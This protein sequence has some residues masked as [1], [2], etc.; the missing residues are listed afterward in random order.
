MVE[1]AGEAGEAGA[2]RGAPRECDTNKFQLQ[3]RSWKSTPYGYTHTV[4]FYPHPMLQLKSESAGTLPV[5]TDSK[6]T[7]VMEK[8][9]TALEVAVDTLKLLSEI[10]G[11]VPDR[12]IIIDCVKRLIEIHKAVSDDET[13]ASEVLNNILKVSHVLAKGLRDSHGPGQHCETPFG[14]IPDWVAESRDQSFTHAK[15]LGIVDA[16][17]D[18]R[19]NA[20]R[21]AFNA[22]D[23]QGFSLN[24]SFEQPGCLDPGCVNLRCELGGKGGPGGPGAVGGPGGIGEGPRVTVFHPQI[25]NMTVHGD[26]TNSPSDTREK[27][28][29]W[30]SPAKVAISQRDAAQKRHP[31]TGLWLLGERTEFI[32]WIY[33][34][35]SL[36]WLEGISGSG[37]TMLSS[38]IIATL[39]ARAEPLAYFYFDT[40][41]SEQR[42]VTQLLCS[43]VWQISA[44]GPSPDTILNKLWRCSD[45]QDLPTDTELISDALIPILKELTEPVYIML[46]AL[47]E[48]SERDHLLTTITTILDADL[49]NVHLLLTSRPEVPRSSTKLAEHAVP[50]CLE[51]CTHQ[52]IESYLTKKLSNFDYG[53]SAERQGEIRKSLLK[54]GSGMFLL[55]SL[56][57][58]ELRDCDGSDH[59]I[60]E[61]L[62]T[63]P[64]SL[65]EIY[66]RII[67]NIKKPA[68]VSAVLRAMN[69]LI[70]SEDSLTVK[71]II[72]ELAFDFDQEPLRFSKA[73]R[74]QRNTFLK[75]CAG[76]VAVSQDEWDDED[77]DYAEV[78]KLVHASVK[79]YFLSQKAP[80]EAVGDYQH[81]SKQ[82]A[83]HLLAR[84]IDHLLEKDTYCQQYPL[85]NYAVSYW[86]FHL[87]FCDEIRLAQYGGP[88]IGSSRA[89]SS[90]VPKTGDFNRKT[91]RLVDIALELFHADSTPYL[92]LS[93]LH[94]LDPR[95][96][97]ED[98]NEFRRRWEW[99]PI[100]P[101]L[102]R[103]VFVGVGPLSKNAAEFA[104]FTPLETATMPSTIRRLDISR[105]QIIVDILPRFN[106]MGIISAVPSLRNLVLTGLTLGPS[107]DDPYQLSTRDLDSLYLAWSPDEFRRLIPFRT[108]RLT[109]EPLFD[110]SSDVSS[111]SRYLRHVGGHLT[112]LHLVLYGMLMDPRTQR[113][114]EMSK[115]DFTP[116]VRLRHLR[117]SHLDI[118][119]VF[120]VPLDIEHFLGLIPPAAVPIID[121]NNLLP[122]TP[123]THFSALFRNFTGVRIKHTYRSFSREMDAF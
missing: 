22:D 34:R 66:A 118:S 123:L 18:R 119:V 41:N 52:D 17:L 28:E 117:I 88:L 108:R 31:K 77:E 40:N 85:I 24:P 13:R 38:T 101:P 103:S 95:E 21:D 78:V 67:K 93:R 87:K 33:A 82:T 104:V 122:P 63:M 115:I 99:A 83:H 51:D 26:V 105:D 94:N 90:V 116:I 39:R 100:L 12:S 30:L 98:W 42:T 70:F 35:N 102:Y 74:M 8:A 109:L 97:W 64:S 68:M 72:D 11:N 71:E 121:A 47:D 107:D 1:E 53:W 65:D 2:A 16:I 86:S 19:L 84:T 57:L 43:L 14:Q 73:R 56:Q 50:V 79:E 114:N 111:I 4:C 32:Q 46:D 89:Q 76:F 69:W 9:N 20:F 23:D 62:A 45:G 81:I 60:N 37:K 3:L 96:D 80:R 10:T 36:L 112:Y 120:A 25:S 48:C 110:V 106:F 44:R 6:T 27:L 55:V 49:P 54:H 58:D 59:E 15:F 75:A 29:K 61:A 5:T 113:G 7:Q 91:T 92:N